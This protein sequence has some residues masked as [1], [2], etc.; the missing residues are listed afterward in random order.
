MK[1]Q[2]EITTKTTMAA[3]RDDDSTSKSYSIL[4]LDPSANINEDNQHVQIELRSIINHLKTFEDEDQFEQYIQ[5]IPSHKRLI[6]IVNGRLGKEVVPRIHHIPQVYSIY[7]YCMD[8]KRNEQWAKH[9]S[10]VGFF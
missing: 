1:C 10:K 8:K 5:S 4:W 7:V 2:F 6:L 3:R 9:Y